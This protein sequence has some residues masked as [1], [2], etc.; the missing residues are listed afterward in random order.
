MITTNHVGVEATGTGTVRL[1]DNSIYNNLTGFGCG[2][3]TLA[4]AANN[5]KAGN[6][7]G[8]LRS[9]RPRS[10]SRSSSARPWQADGYGRPPAAFSPKI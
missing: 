7:G 9:A 1:S 2:G 4:S 6:T 8:V 3:R 5:R 10:P